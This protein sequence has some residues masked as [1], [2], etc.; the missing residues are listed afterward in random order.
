MSV[1]SQPTGTFDTDIGFGI[2][3]DT[4]TGTS[5]YM[6]SSSNIGCIGWHSLGIDNHIASSTGSGVLASFRVSIV[7][8]GLD[9]GYREYPVPN[10][11]LLINNMP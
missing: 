8:I 6:V 4:G 9:V 7:A 11:C 10:A 2:V 5:P 1:D 3:T